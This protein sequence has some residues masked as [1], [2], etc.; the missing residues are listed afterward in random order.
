MVTYMDNKIGR[1]HLGFLREMSQQ[2]KEF[3]V[4]QIVF[5]QQQRIKIKYFRT[6]MGGKYASREAQDYLREHGIK[7]ERL[8]PQTPQYNGCVERLNRTII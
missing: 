3:K 6:D 7:W 1:I 8:A 4:Y 2:L 5:K